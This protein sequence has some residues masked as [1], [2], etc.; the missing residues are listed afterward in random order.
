MFIRTIALAIGA[1]LVAVLAAWVSAPVVAFVALQAAGGIPFCYPETYPHHLTHGQCLLHAVPYPT[2]HI[3]W[4]ETYLKAA[5]L[6]MDLALLS[7][8]YLSVPAALGLVACIAW[9]G[10]RTW[11]RANRESVDGS[12]LQ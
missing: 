6:R 8:I 12:V 3:P 9:A 5:A 2:D 4:W 11:R 7:G 1:I 10:G